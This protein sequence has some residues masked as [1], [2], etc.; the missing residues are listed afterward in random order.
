M[1]MG[2]Q[3]LKVGEQYAHFSTK[4]SISRKALLE[5]LTNEHSLQQ[6]QAEAL[7]KAM[8]TNGIIKPMKVGAALYYQGTKA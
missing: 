3:L 8:I 5:E 1:A 6:D 7:V 2:F 4:P